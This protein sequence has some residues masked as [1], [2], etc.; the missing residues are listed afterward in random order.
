ME[1]FGTCNVYRATFD[2][3]VDHETR[4]DEQPTE[5]RLLI[6]NDF[7]EAV[8]MA[9]AMRMDVRSRSAVHKETVVRDVTL[10]HAGVLVTRE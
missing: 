7:L 2:L 5:E 1:G 3:V 9:R 8:E 10:V 6:A 4:V